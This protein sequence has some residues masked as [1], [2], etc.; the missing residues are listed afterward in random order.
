MTKIPAFDR[1]GNAALNVKIRS[2]QLQL[3]PCLALLKG[4]V[5]NRINRRH[6]NCMTGV[7]DTRGD[8]ANQGTV[9][10]L[11]TVSAS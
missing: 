11:R 2:F 9:R 3:M 4:A 5:D 6:S 1:A 10:F 8:A 7:T